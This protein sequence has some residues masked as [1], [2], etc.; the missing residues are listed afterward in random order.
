M[1]EILLITRRE[2]RKHLRSVKGIFLLALSILGGIAAA[3][4]MTA[5]QQRG[6]DQFGANVLLKLGEASAKELYGD[7]IGQALSSVPLTLLSLL[8]LTI[9]IAPFLISMIGFDTLAGELQFKTI[10]YW[11][12]RVERWSLVIGK[13]IGLWIVVSLMTLVTHVAVWSYVVYN[14]NAAFLTTV[15]WGALLWSATLPLSL[16]WCAL[17]IGTS[18]QTRSPALSFIAIQG[19]FF[20]IWL[21]QHW[22][23][24]IYPNNYDVFVLSPRLD[25]M[26]LGLGACLLYTGVVTGLTCAAFA[27][28]DL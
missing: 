1:R 7:E 15:G 5:L 4:S 24:Y 6:I 25:Q 8:P 19:V 14:G 28:R 20:G 11:A 21:G 27:R 13:T 3:V 26:L 22:L 23:K 16:P 9:W 12:T 10:R 18:A 17:A 2:L